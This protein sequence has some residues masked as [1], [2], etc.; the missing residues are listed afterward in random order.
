MKD[1][2][3]ASRWF[4]IPRLIPYMRPYGRLILGMVAASPVVILMDQSVYAQGTGWPV[5][6]AGAVTLVLG[7]IISGKLGDE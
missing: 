6:V 4:G 2:H 3:S 7:F 1:T 5:L